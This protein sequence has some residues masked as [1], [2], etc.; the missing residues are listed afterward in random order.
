MA[1][2]MPTVASAKVPRRGASSTPVDGTAARAAARSAW[3]GESAACAAAPRR[4]AAAAAPLGAE[5]TDAD[6]RAA[7][8]LT[9]AARSQSRDAVRISRACAALHSANGVVDADPEAAGSQYVRGGTGPRAHLC[10]GGD[11]AELHHLL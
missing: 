2:K 5:P 1:A 9:Y 11:E 3:A 7:A 10:Q 8:A 4:N 6:G